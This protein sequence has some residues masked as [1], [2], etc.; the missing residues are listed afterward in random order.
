M[1][2]NSPPQINISRIRVGGGIGAAALIVVLLAAM[3]A[4]LIAVRW[5]ALAGTV[6]GICVGLLLIL[7]RRKRGL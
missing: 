4:E 2:E 1:A 3:S 5:L 6:T 7:R